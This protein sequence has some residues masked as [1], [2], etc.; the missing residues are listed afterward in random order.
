M[1]LE[2][3]E[4]GISF[5]NESNEIELDQMKIKIDKNDSKEEQ[6]IELESSLED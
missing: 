5:N 6:K 2:K 1:Q 3:I 4:S